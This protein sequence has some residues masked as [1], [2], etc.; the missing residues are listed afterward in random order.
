MI[1][2]A[3][4]AAVFLCACQPAPV[5]VRN[6]ELQSDS[7][8]QCVALCQQIGLPLQSVVIMANNVG[9]VCAAAPPP[10]M[11]GAPGGVSSADGASGGMAAIMIAEQERAA[12]Q[13]SA[14]QTQAAQAKH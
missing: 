6:V 2:L 8:Q 12:A 13:A 4:I 9:C 7:A 11:P 14:A 5:G 1:R 10:M 3:M